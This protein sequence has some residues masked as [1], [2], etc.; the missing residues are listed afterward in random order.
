M[1]IDYGYGHFIYPKINTGK[2]ASLLNNKGY[3]VTVAIYSCPS[4]FVI[5]GDADTSQ[6]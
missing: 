5:A 3:L 4:D 1:D 6:K 2:H